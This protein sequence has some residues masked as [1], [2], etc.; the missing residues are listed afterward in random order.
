MA[1]MRLLLGAGAVVGE[2]AT[3][4]PAIQALAVI[5]LVVLGLAVTHSDDRTRRAVQLIDPYR[6]RR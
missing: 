3:W 1:G 4:S 5:A 2:I 6:G